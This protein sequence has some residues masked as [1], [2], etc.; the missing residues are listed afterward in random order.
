MIEAEEPRKLLGSVDIDR[1]YAGSEPNA[2]RWEYVIG[3][4]SYPVP[5]AYF[6]EVHPVGIEEIKQIRLK[7]LWLMEKLKN[8]PFLNPREWKT[9][10]HWV[11]PPEGSIPFTKQQVARKLPGVPIEF[12]G[13][14]PLRL[15]G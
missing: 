14:G 11:V 10:Y 15:T 8:S 6:V 4:R 13:R 2:S 7:W 3:Y 1:W 5:R 9:S 12:E